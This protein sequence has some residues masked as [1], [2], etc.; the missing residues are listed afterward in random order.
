MDRIL[1]E[2]NGA[3]DAKRNLIRLFLPICQ[4][5]GIRYFDVSDHLEV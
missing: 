4:V 3:K 2:H 5:Y 1:V